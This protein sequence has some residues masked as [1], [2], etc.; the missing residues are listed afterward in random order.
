MKS[1]RS[2]LRFPFLERAV[3]GSIHRFR[4]DADELQSEFLQITG[5]KP[6]PL[7][8]AEYDQELL[9]NV[10]LRAAWQA[11]PGVG[12]V[13]KHGSYEK[14]ILGDKPG[15]L[16]S[17]RWCEQAH[18]RWSLKRARREGQRPQ[19]FLPHLIVTRP[20]VFSRWTF[21]RTQGRSLCRRQCIQT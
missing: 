7:T 4:R 19:G 11:I 18:L 3:M 5:R 12:P 21:Q 6:A 2:R 16:F 17:T 13:A 1:D 10:A 15:T 20:A 9:E 8:S 14:S